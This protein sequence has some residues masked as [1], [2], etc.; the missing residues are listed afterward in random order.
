M[1]T[2]KAQVVFARFATAWRNDRLG[3]LALISAA[4]SFGLF[5]APPFSSFNPNMGLL[6]W[7]VQFSWYHENFGY[8]VGS[9]TS[10]DLGLLVGGFSI[11]LGYDYPG[12]EPIRL[13]LYSGWFDGWEVNRLLPAIGAFLALAVI[14]LLLR[15]R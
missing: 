11:R 3:A 2:S 9:L 1:A 12:S 15:R 7:P 4:I 5:A 10:I 13:W 6:T 14:I 8:T